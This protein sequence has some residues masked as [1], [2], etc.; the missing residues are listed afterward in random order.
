MGHE[1]ARVV[2]GVEQ[3]DDAG[4]AALH[5]VGVADCR[6][7]AVVGAVPVDQQGRGPRLS[8]VEGPAQAQVDEALVVAGELARLDHVNPFYSARQLH[9]KT[10][11][12]HRS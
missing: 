6:P 8:G 7:R 5:H 3:P 12:V 2:P 9:L 11:Y 4:A 1:E 10:K